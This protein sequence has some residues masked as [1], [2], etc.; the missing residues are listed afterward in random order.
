MKHAFILDSGEWEGKGKISFSMAEDELNF[1]MKWKVLPAEKGVIRCM[2]CI[3]VDGVEDKMENTFSFTEPAGQNFSLE[4]ENHLVGRVIGKGLIEPKVI[5]W[6]F[7]KTPQLFEG[8]EIYKLQEDG[9]YSV[10]AE[11]T[12]GEGL[13]TYVKGMI[14]RKMTVFSVY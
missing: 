12:A 10:R 9:S 14:Q 6:E 11:F 13:R 7:C 2:Q 5:A 3:H 4:L 1:S 8:F